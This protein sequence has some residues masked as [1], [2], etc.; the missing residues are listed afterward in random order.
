MQ[1]YFRRFFSFLQESWLKSHS[2]LDAAILDLPLFSRR[3]RRIFPTSLTGDVT[4]E[5]AQDDWE[6]GCKPSTSLRNCLEFSQPYCLSVNTERFK[7]SSL[8]RYV[9]KY[10]LAVQI[11]DLEFCNLIYLYKCFKRAR[12]DVGLEKDL[13]SWVYRKAKGTSPNRVAQRYQIHLRQLS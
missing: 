13:K 7:N 9:F 10:N 5:I 8:K 1:I 3:P 6:R 4:S 12:K 11:L 2:W